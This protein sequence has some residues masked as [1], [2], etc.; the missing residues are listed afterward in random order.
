MD[1]SVLKGEL[2]LG[3]DYVWRNYERTGFC[4]TI[5]S[6]TNYPDGF[7]R[8]D[9]LVGIPVSLKVF[10]LYLWG[11]LPHDDPACYLNIHASPGFSTYLMEH[12]STYPE[13]T[14][15]NLQLAYYLGFSEVYLVGLDR[16][17]CRPLGDKAAAEAVKD[18]YRKAREAFEKDGRRIYNA[19]V[20][21]SYE[22]FEP[23]DFR[24][25]FVTGT[26]RAAP[27][28][29]W[30]PETNSEMRTAKVFERKPRHTLIS[31]N[32]ML[33]DEFG[34]Y[35]PYDQMLFREAL[36]QGIEM[37]SLGSRVN[38]I[39]F[40][41]KN[42][43]VIPLFIRQARPNIG[44]MAGAST[45][46]KVFRT[47]LLEGLRI[48]KDTYGQDTHYT[49]FMYTGSV[50]HAKAIEEVVGDDPLLDGVVALFY[51]SFVN[52]DDP[53]IRSF[54]EAMLKQV[55][56]SKRV[57]LLVLAAEMKAYFRQIFGI[58][59][60]VL[61]SP[62][63]TYSDG[64]FTGV[65]R[66]SR[67]G[68]RRMNVVFPGSLLPEKGY[69]LAC[70]F[71]TLVSRTP[72][73]KSR[74]EVSLRYVVRDNTPPEMAALADALGDDVTLYKGSLDHMAFKSMI[75]RADILA[76][77]YSVESFGRRAA[78]SISD[79]LW[80]G[81]PVLATSGTFP[82]NL[83]KKYRTGEVFEEN[84]LESITDAVIKLADDYETYLENAWQARFRWFESHSW[85]RLMEV[86]S[87]QCRSGDSTD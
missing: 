39:D 34:H 5:L 82:G 51:A 13:V 60:D 1:L 25:V 85:C 86:V 41:R 20:G 26:Q 52:Y 42:P 9:G 68:G 70:R 74:F 75:E 11:Q 58:K 17:N 8:L 57:R 69:E 53:S 59:L 44:E 21:D 7:Q 14:Y 19:T 67:V 16:G 30:P 27:C 64:A 32:P 40:E 84:S 12:A 54:H 77:P 38:E 28:A 87:G 46:L 31:V 6:I 35:L 43:Y 3:G 61:P 63:T 10:P 49:L 47:Q 33:A 76:I 48:V 56:N 15:F 83:V 55:A 29:K 2:T 22:T 66:S 18:T 81:K 65:D 4:S 62:S 36:R 50:F 37:V 72:D 45:D 79:A 80:L 23:V 78:N 24:D 71:A 73:L